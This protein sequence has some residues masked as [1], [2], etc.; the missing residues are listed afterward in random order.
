M[1][2][3]P[4]DNLPRIKDGAY[5]ID[6]DDKESKGPYWVLLFIDMI[7]IPL[8]TFIFLEL[9]IFCHMYQAKSKT[10]LSRNTYVEC[11]LMLLLCVEF[12]ASTSWTI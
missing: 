12:T 4:R 11:S 1:L 6:L 10:N 7:E 8:C 2:F 3:F 9:N 5:V